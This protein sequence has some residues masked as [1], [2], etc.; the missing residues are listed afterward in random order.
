MN[1]VQ[2]SACHRKSNVVTTLIVWYTIPIAKY[3]LRN[4]SKLL[5][6]MDVVALGYLAILYIL[7]YFHCCTHFYNTVKSIP[8]M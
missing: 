3:R 5:R 2:R 7:A 1:M 4:M 8:K 6:N